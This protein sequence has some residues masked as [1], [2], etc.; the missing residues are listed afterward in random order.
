[1]ADFQLRQSH[2]RPTLT[3]R[4]P[5]ASPAWG[6]PAAS[7]RDQV[8]EQLVRAVSSRRQLTPQPEP[9]IDP[10][11]LAVARFDERAALDAAVVLERVLHLD[12]IDVLRDRARRGSRCRA[13]GPT[14]ASRVRR[15]CSGREHGMRRARRILHRRVLVGDAI[16]ADR[17]R[18]RPVLRLVELRLVVLD[19]R[20]SRRSRRI[21]AGGDC[22]RADRRAARRRARRS[23]WCGTST[24][25]PQASSSLSIS[26][27]RGAELLHRRWHLV[28]DA[29]DVA[30]RQ[31]PAGP[32]RR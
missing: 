1:M 16:R 7:Q 12:E 15:S 10:A 17:R 21:S 26:V 3:A 13:P 22:S 4:P 2:I 30:D 19:D 8:R 6:R 11:A 28:A 32:R 9:D 5:A 31:R 18:I 27:T 24:R 25:S 29:H 23:R 20:P 14:P